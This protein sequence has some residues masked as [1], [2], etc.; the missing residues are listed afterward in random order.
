[1]VAWLAANLIPAYAV[2]STNSASNEGVTVETSGARLEA[3]KES[4]AQRYARMAWWREA[5]FGLF[6]HRG[7][8]SVPAGKYGDST[9]HGEWIIKPAKIP[10][11]KCREFAEQFN[12][13]K[14]AV[15][16]TR[17]EGRRCYRSRSRYCRRILLQDG[18]AHESRTRQP[19][20]T[21]A[22]Q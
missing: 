14:Q 7:N 15:V 20:G 10:V 4:P 9:G 11:A 21:Y 5:K 18:G 13:V 6:I 8:Y 19:P 1:M 3:L 17:P 22:R 16:F 2:A 12:P